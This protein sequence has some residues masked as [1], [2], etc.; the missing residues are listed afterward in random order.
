MNKKICIS[1]ACALALTTTLVASEDLGLISVDSSTIDDKFTS[2]KSSVSNIAIISEEDI[3]KSNPHSVLDILNTIPG[4]TAESVDNDIVKIHIRGVENQRYMGE[5]SGVAVV[6]DGVPVQESAGRVNIDLDNI[7]SIKVIKGSAS[8]LYGNDAIAG[9]VVITTKRGKGE[10]LSKIEIERGR[11][12]SNKFLASTN[13]SFENSA[14]K[15]QASSRS[16]DGYYEDAYLKHKSVNGKY[17]YY[18]DDSSDLTFGLDYTNRKSGDGNSVKGVDA[19]TTN[20]RSTNYVSYSAY[21]DSDLTKSFVTYSKDFEDESN[22][23]F[24]I[25]RYEDDKTKYSGRISSGAYRNLG[26]NDFVDENWV[27]NGIKSEYRV[28]YDNFAFMIGADAQRNDVKT[29]T[30]DT[31]ITQVVG[32]LSGSTK[33]DED[34]NAIYFELK[35]ELSSNLTTTVNA[36]YDGI[37]YNYRDD[38]NSSLNTTPKY[39]HT[40]YRAGLNYDLSSTSSLYTSIS[41]GFK[42]PTASQISTNLTAISEGYDV[43]SSLKEETSINYEIGIRA[44]KSGFEYDAAIFQLDRKDY[45]GKRGGAYI[46]RNEDDEDA[47]YFNLGDL[48]S[49]GF[50]LALQSDKKKEI[51]YNLAYA[52]LNATYKK[53]T[54]LYNSVSV[55]ISGNQVPRTSKHTVNLSVDYKPTDKLTISPEFI[56]KSSYF[57]DDMNHYKQ[58]GYKVAN[59]KGTYKIK[60]GLEAFAR[61]DNLFNR[62]Y[63]SF[64]HLSNYETAKDMDDATIRVAAPRA[65]YA[66]VRYKF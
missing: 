33:T 45:I 64:V 52:H 34:I 54:M 30:Y 12:N 10:D 57:A 53:M 43:P 49:R 9:A 35:N 41:T 1:L 48:Q 38:M 31:D 40:S 42:A 23:M 65:L 55:D 24:N 28:P 37:K 29:L 3:E 58:K 62:N 63:Y 61:I 2:T 8:Y 17:Q 5:R 7:A 4:L 59:L 16:T 66:G 13:Q 21:Y 56:V 36:R 26:H 44:S 47:Y 11:F 25:H 6:I 14:L 60:K 20:P 51:S 27:Q 50:E 22:F 32:A 18:I 15:V 39:T 19:A 46:D